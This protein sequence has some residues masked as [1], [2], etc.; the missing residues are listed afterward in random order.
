M[1]KVDA[2]VEST[3]LVLV[4]SVITTLEL[5]HIVMFEVEGIEIPVRLYLSL[6]E[7]SRIPIGCGAVYSNLLTTH[8]LHILFA[9]IHTQ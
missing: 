5:V 9:W 1:P 3:P 6:I 7:Y 4:Y 8:L 2:C